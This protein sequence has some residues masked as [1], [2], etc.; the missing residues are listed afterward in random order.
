MLADLLVLKSCRLM[1]LFVGIIE[2]K[3]LCV[4]IMELMMQETFRTS[5]QDDYSFESKV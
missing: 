4:E 3:C 5:I 1:R 2:S